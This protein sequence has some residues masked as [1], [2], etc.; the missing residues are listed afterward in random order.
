MLKLRL[1][2]SRIS[3]LVSTTLFIAWITTLRCAL[4]PN[5]PEPSSW[6]ALAVT[7]RSVA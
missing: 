3:E 6:F 5:V 2:S 7:Q 1:S 4:R